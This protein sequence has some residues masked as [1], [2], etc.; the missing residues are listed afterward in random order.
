M[1]GWSAGGDRFGRFAGLRP[2]YFL[3]IGAAVLAV[4]AA[5]AEPAWAATEAWRPFEPDPVPG[6]PFRGPGC[7]LSW[8]KILSAWLVF[9]AWVK[10]TDWLST[11][12]QDLRLK[13]LNYLVWNPI[14]FGTFVV[15]F[16]LLW[17]LP[18]FPIG[19]ILLLL[20][21]VTP[22]ATYVIYRNSLV[23]N[24]QRVGT[25]EHLRYWFATHLHR[26]GVKIE[27]EK[28]D[29]RNPN[30]PLKLFGHGGPDERTNNARLLLARQS[31]GLFISQEI[32]A[33]A[34][35]NR[36]SAVMLDCTQQGASVNVMVDGVWIPSRS[37]PRELSDPAVEA[38]K[39]LCGLKAQ[40]RQGLQ[41]GTF[42]SEYQ[43]V[44][45]TAT[46]TSQG[47]PTGERVLIQFEDNA[48]RFKSFDDLG[49]RVKMQGQLKELL[50]APRGV[51][52]FA[53]MPGEGLRNT[54]DVALRACDRFVREFVAVEE[55]KTR[56]PRVENIPVTTYS[57]AA[58]QFP[59][60]VLPK[61]LR[62]QPDVVVVRNFVNAESANLL[63][64][65]AAEKLVIGTVRAKDCVESVWK[66]LSLGLRPGDFADAITAVLA[67]R[68]V[69]K[70]CTDC[71]EA[72]APQPQVLQQLG[73]PAGRIE[74]F[75]R[76]RQ[77]PEQPNPKEPYVPCR[78][79]AGIG[80]LGRTAIYELLVVGDRVRKTLKASPSP[81]SLRKAARKDGMKSL[82]EE[83][84]LLVA[85]GVTSLPELARVL[86][87]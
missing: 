12:V 33:D 2:L 36:G 19:F 83:G 47:T 77:R 68:L 42:A 40:E 45:S 56:F 41:S 43:K 50:E 9:L 67:Q 49:M 57:A 29:P 37:K 71:M 87:Q 51:L 16:V 62:S 84:I 70:L 60:T 61:L 44:R 38:L 80:Y 1:G 48:I 17:L 85:K 18:V 4:V 5:A 86:K 66:T 35:A 65:A 75:Y 10:T 79:C 31:P 39:I 69:R 58:E 54:V 14:V 53:A 55:E 72:Y 8:L 74:A 64:E 15:A 25:P 46:F 30:G 63:C 32:L 13:E 3:L 22:L 76:P 21:Y 52:L 7:Y 24:D 20:A 11:D 27:A 78:T 81:Q 82:Q 73:I 23:E 6:T 28:P 34:L 26:V 59:A